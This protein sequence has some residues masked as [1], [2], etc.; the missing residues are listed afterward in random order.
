M[1]DIVQA[2]MANIKVVGVGGAGNNGVNRMVDAGLK[3]IE[4]ISINTD[5]QALQSSKASKKI[6]IGEKLTRGLGA[7]ADPE[8]GRC[9]ADESKTEIAEALKGDRKSV[10]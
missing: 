5:K 2:G 7:G 3:G 1:E 4:F 6:Q 10:V 9:S 8:V